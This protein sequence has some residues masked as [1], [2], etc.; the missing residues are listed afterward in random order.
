[1][2]KQVMK[3]AAAKPA[4]AKQN[5]KEKTKYTK[6]K[7]LAV[8]AAK[9]VAEQAMSAKYAAPA[10]ATKQVAAALVIVPPCPALCHACFQENCL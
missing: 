9:E 7:A 4:E 5:T 6:A 10:K 8:K 1:M 2:T 3:P